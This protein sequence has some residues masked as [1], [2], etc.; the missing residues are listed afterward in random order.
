[1]VA[2][3]IRLRFIKVGL[4]ALFFRLFLGVEVLGGE[5]NLGKLSRI[6]ALSIKY[7]RRILTGTSQ[8]HTYNLPILYST[9]DDVSIYVRL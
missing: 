2:I 4:Q 1:M 8:D 9:P 3:Y 7:I 5:V 6:L